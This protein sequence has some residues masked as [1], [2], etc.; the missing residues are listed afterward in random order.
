MALDD[1]LLHG[2]PATRLAIVKRAAKQ[3]VNAR[4]GD[5]IGLILFGTRA[6][7]Q[8]PLTYDH[9]NVLLRLE[10]ATVGL[11]GQTTSI[12][13]ALGLAIK[14]LQQVPRAG[15]MIILLTDGANNSGLLAPLKAAE[16]ARLETIKVYTIGLG[17]NIETGAL[18]GAFPMNASSDLDEGTLQAIAQLTGGRYFRATD[19]E[20]LHEIYATINQME[21]VKHDEATIRPQKD[22]YPWPLAFALVLFLLWLIRKNAFFQRRKRARV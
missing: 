18:N 8:T 9:Q 2:Q 4:I 13:D 17:A 7:L 6:Y 1:M 21:T 20:S 16:L 12:G 3:F 5:H 11:A 22:Y 10:D 14:R 19:A 15:R